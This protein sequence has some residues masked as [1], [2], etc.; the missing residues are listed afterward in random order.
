MSNDDL[1]WLT[2]RDELYFLEKKKP[3]KNN[4]LIRNWNV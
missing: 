2:A 1:K 3:N 4:T